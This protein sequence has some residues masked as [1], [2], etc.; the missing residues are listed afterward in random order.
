M[1]PTRTIGGAALY[2][3]DCLD[4]L[5]GGALPGE[6]V[7]ACIADPPYGIDFHSGSQTGKS[8]PAFGRIAN[9]KAPYIWWI[10]FAARALRP[11]GCLACFSRWD[12]QDVFIRALELA[13][14]TVRSVVVWDKRCHGMGNLR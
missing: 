7:A 3:G 9:D 11:D 5:G 10:P 8:R 12:V 14:L 1:E 2:R 13:G 6:S 4:V